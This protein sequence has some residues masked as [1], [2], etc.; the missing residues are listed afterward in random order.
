VS[1]SPQ[2]LVLTNLYLQDNQIKNKHG[3]IEEVALA[4]STVVL[5]YKAGI[6]LDTGKE[7][8]IKLQ[9][10]RDNIASVW[11]LGSDSPRRWY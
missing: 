7:I 10:I 3:K 6:D 8:A 11:A 2:K 4:L 9:H 5:F 1:S